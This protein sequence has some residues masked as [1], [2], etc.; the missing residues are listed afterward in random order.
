MVSGTFVQLLIAVTG[1]II[2]L[3]VFASWQLI[4]FFQS[5]L[6]NIGSL[7]FG[8]SIGWSSPLSP[9]II[10]K[11][12]FINFWIT[13]YE[14][15]WIVGAMALGGALSSV[16]SGIVRNKFGT[17]L[18]ILMFGF[19]GMM[20][21]L[22]I[23][24][25]V[26]ARMMLIGRF[27]KGMSVGC[28]IFVS[29]I[30]VAEI[31]S[32]HIRG[33]MLCTFQIMLNAG[34]L[35]AF[36]VGKFAQ[37]KQFNVICGLVPSIFY[38]TAV[39]FL[40]E[41]PVYLMSKNREDEAKRSLQMLRDDESQIQ[42]ELS[43]LKKHQLERQTKIVQSPSEKTNIL[44]SP[45]TRK[46]FVIILIQFVFY[47]MS[48]VNAVAFYTT[49]IF[50]ESGIELDP[51]LATIGVS[52]GQLLIAFCVIILVDRFGRKFLLV[53][54]EAIMCMGMLGIGT[55]FM[56]NERGYDL[57][58]F[59]WLP[60]V[61]IAAC[62][63]A[64]SFGLG[65]VTFILLGELFTQEAKS[66]VAPICSTLNFLLMFVVGLTF[67]MLTSVIGCGLT[68]LMYGVVLIAALTFAIFAIPETKGISL[69]GIQKLLEK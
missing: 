23:I 59:R 8:V 25:A 38:C 9:K 39:T 1:V 66:V 34:I 56:L 65:P 17:R 11:Y 29:P 15:S 69:Q 19:I 49:S 52:A 42:K 53:T 48:G 35:F 37:F 32:S 36:T 5:C 30:Y 68:F 13:K 31:S 43:E 45:A 10:E 14:F 20:G 7:L 51:Y 28:F 50:I 24:F 21:W 57:S 63:I 18:T 6:V 67:L 61:C 16:L 62:S 60:V 26:D 41:S 46:A 33:K 55:Y 2:F 64:F 12:D 40:P 3:R 27:L 4:S 44:S 47:Q 54:S 58:A 22:S